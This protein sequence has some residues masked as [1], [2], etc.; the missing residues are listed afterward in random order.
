MTEHTIGVDISKS[1]LDVF[2]LE[3]GAAQRFENSAA[4][5]RALARW[6]GKGPVARVVF[7][8][9]G[10]Y[11][12]AFEAA[13]GAT[14]PLVK[15]NP[16]QARRF[17]QA[18]GTRARTDAVDARM[19]ARMGAA[20]D[21][22]PQA[23]RSKEARVLKDLHVAC[24]GLIKDRTRLRNRAQTQDV[25]ILKR[26]T[27]A[28]L[29]QVERQIAELDAEI[30]ALIEAH[31]TTARNRDILCSMPGVGA[32]TAA[33]M[34]TLMPEIGTLARKQ[35]ASLTGLAPVTRQSGQ[36]QGKSFITGG[37]KPLRDALYMPA[38]VAM[39]FNPDLKAK[40]EHLR[41]AGKPAKVAIVAIMRKLIETANALVKA[42]RKWVPKTA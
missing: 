41:A 31:Q 27:K 14:L 37:R 18:Y 29:A 25:A 7:E 20:F 34:L 22:A 5:F 38:L 11:H 2:R 9:T 19:L 23:Q 4:G 13:L 26:Q 40:Y 36:W 21:L 8:P 39:R 3:D 16:L 1:H 28:R 33:A 32:V 10:P 35:V 24:A 15:V 30:A 6:L 12:K 42:D 17:A